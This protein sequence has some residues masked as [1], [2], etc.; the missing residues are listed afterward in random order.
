MARAG[1]HG[2]RLEVWRPEC[3]VVGPLCRDAMLDRVAERTE[4]KPALGAPARR[5]ARAAK[6][7][8]TAA[9]PAYAREP[10]AQR[11]ARSG[12]P[13][14]AGQVN[15]TQPDG[16]LTYALAAARRA[17]RPLWLAAVFAWI[18][19]ALAALSSRA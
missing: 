15:L 19:P 3:R 18:T 2:L 16:A 8:A 14:G 7:A 12:E 6:R 1:C 17:R 9:Y 4:A 10:T 5:A 11:R 13:T